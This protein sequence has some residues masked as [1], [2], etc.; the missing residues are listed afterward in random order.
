MVAIWVL[1]NAD[2]RLHLLEEFIQ[3]L[4]RKET[5]SD[6]LRGLEYIGLTDSWHDNIIFDKEKM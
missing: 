1:E 5:W 3:T 6:G 2:R 4:G